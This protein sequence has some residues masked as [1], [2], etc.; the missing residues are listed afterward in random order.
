MSHPTLSSFRHPRPRSS[1]RWPDGTA[2]LDRRLRA[3]SAPAAP[4][5]SAATAPASPRCCASIAG[6]LAPTSGL[7]AAS[8]RRRV[9]SAAAH[10]RRRSTRRRAARRRREALDALRAIE[11]GDVD[12]RHFDAV[13]DDWDIEARADA[14]RSP[15]PGSPPTCSTARVGEL[16]GGEAVLVAIAGIRLRAR[17][18]RCS[19]SRPTTSTATRGRGS[20]RWSAAGAGTLIVVSHDLVAAR[21]DGRHG[22]AVRRAR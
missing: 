5:S 3:P 20:A 10:A 6:E 16:S 11:S 22:R 18:S 7:V 2:A 4:A 17:R 1:S 12:P 13:G 9:P 19:T 14:R 8:R 21:A 15:K